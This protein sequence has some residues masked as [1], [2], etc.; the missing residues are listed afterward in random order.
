MA[1]KTVPTEVPVEDF[2]A[3][4]D[5]KRVDDARAILEIMRDATGTEPV[6]WGPSIIG[7]G[8]VHMTYESGRELDWMLV[9]FSPRKRE[10]VLYIMPGFSQYE[11]LLAKLGPHRKGSSCLYVKRLDKV[12]VGVLTELVR[13]SVAHMREKYA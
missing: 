3:T 4:V 10:Q 1:N 7:F 5:P 8:Q 2:L 12:D 13:D 11:D 9:G 6:M